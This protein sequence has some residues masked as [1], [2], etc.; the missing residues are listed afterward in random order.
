[1]VT[2]A[3]R[4]NSDRKPVLLPASTQLCDSSG[5]N[6]GTPLS[7]MVVD[8]SEGGL[9]LELLS[10]PSVLLQRD[11]T[12]LLTFD[13]AHVEIHHPLTLRVAW[14]KP[15]SSETPGRFQLGATFLKIGSGERAAL[16][17]A[18]MRANRPSTEPRG[19]WKSLLPLAFGLA[20]IVLL[21][22]QVKISQQQEATRQ[23]LQDLGNRV[24]H[25][26]D[27]VHEQFQSLAALGQR[28]IT[29]EARVF[30]LETPDAGR[31]PSSS[32]VGWPK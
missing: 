27:S 8:V 28:V 14:V 25:L 15:A 31:V 18:A 5:Q 26:E 3:E 24:D 4:R 20:L 23:A 11:S 9:R 10:S 2:G 7:A 17:R 22:W 30:T 16:V 29:L 19:R 13:R 21:G 1:M 6:P 12:I 32:A